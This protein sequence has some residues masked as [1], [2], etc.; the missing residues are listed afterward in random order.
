M[1]DPFDI[2]C[3]GISITYSD[4]LVNINFER[5]DPFPDGEPTM[6]RMGTIRFPPEVLKMTAFLLHKF[7]TEYERL[8]G[9]EYPYNPRVLSGLN[10]SEDEWRRFWGTLAG[11]ETNDDQ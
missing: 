8:T 6:T 11:G 2:T 3:D 5:A 7:V 10:V 1:P 4:Y 9:K